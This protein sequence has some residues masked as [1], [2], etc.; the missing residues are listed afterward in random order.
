[1]KFTKT[2]IDHLILS[3]FSFIS[4]YLSYFD[5]VV[6]ENIFCLFF[7]GVYDLDTLFRR[8]IGFMVIEF[9]IHSDAFLLHK[10]HLPYFLHEHH[11]DMHKELKKRYT[12]S[13]NFDK[14]SNIPVH[15]D[16]YF[17]YIYVFIRYYVIQSFFK[18]HS[19]F[20][21]YFYICLLYGVFRKS[22]YFILSQVQE[23]NPILIYYK[24]HFLNEKH[25]YGGPMPFYDV[26]FGTTPLKYIPIPIPYVDFFIYK[27]KMI[28]TLSHNKYVP[29]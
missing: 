29:Q 20:H 4:N 1:M 13:D 5:L 28:N 15:T 23:T 6:F 2:P 18:I 26:L 7:I 12:Q 3:F 27:S 19:N 25:H 10:F 17:Y 24:H 11:H 22:F 21:D 9:I 8:Y 14:K 16:T